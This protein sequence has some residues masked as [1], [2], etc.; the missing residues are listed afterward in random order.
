MLPL[1]AYSVMPAGL[2][3]LFRIIIQLLAWFCS[4]LLSG[5]TAFF[6]GVGLSSH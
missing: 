6:V 5:L 1:L 4:I 3:T 2:S